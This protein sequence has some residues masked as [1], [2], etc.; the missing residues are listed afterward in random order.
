MLAVVPNLLADTADNLDMVKENTQLKQRV[1]KL[2]WELAELKKLVLQQAADSKVNQQKIDAAYSSKSPVIPQ[3]SQADMQK[4]LTMVRKNME[5]KKSVWSN[6]DIQLYGYIKVDATY[7]SSRTTTGNYA[8]YVDRENTNKDDNESNMTANQTRIGLRITGPEDEGLKTS[9]LI[10]ADF[11]G[12]GDENK[13]RLRLR[14][15]YLK[16]DW[17][18]DKFDIIAGQTWDVISPLYPNTLNFTILWG[19]GNIGHRHPQIRLTKRY[20]VTQDVKL[21]LEGAISRTIGD[22]DINT[23]SGEDSGFPT[24]Q[25]RASLT[26]PWFGHKPTTI[27]F[28]SHWGQEE[29]EHGIASSTDE[30]FDSWSLNLDWNQPVN[31][32]LTVKAEV[33]TGENLDNYFGGIGQGVRKTGV[34]AATIYHN[35]IKSKGGWIAA[36]LGP[37]D[38]WSFNTGVGIDDV[39]AGDVTDGD[40]TLNRS[41]FGNVIYAFNKHAKVGFELSHWRTDYKGDGDAD[42]LRAQT[43]FIYSF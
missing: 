19:A 31:K 14:H 32:W 26:F 16:F 33:F 7:D 21:K 25:G 24:L 12:G 18:D 17:P 13:S 2:E 10:E 3:L 29:F 11:Y 43:S 28:S 5:T 22:D 41:I 20:D 37:W 36:S 30:E 40:R 1:D 38:K 4:I 15:A 42:S 27:G 9:G 39:D 8:L 23:K 35:A 6:L 34:G